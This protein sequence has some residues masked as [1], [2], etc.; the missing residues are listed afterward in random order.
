MLFYYN[1]E[2]FLLGGAAWAKSV[3]N[4]ELVRGV[5]LGMGVDLSMN[6]IKR[7]GQ[8]LRDYLPKTMVYKVEELR[9]IYRERYP[10]KVKKIKVPL[11]PDRVKRLWTLRRLMIPK[12]ARRNRDRSRE[13]NNIYGD[14]AVQRLEK[15]EPKT[16]L[17]L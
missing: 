10:D 1:G 15:L 16:T 12:R 4:S 9:P 8:Y 6:P 14:L 7:D 17:I 3:Y 13:M 5:L 2:T 11:T